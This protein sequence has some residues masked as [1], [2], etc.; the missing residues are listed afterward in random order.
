MYDAQNGWTISIDKVYKV[1]NGGAD[2]DY[3]FSA[4]K[5]LLTAVSA[6]DTDIAYVFGRNVSIF[7]TRDGGMNWDE[8]SNGT[9]N[10]LAS[11]FFLN[12]I[13]GW[14]GGSNHTMLH[15]HD[16][17]EHWLYTELPANYAVRDI[18]FTTADSGW[19]VNGGV[20]RTTDGGHYWEEISSSYP[21]YGIFVSLIPKKAGVW[22]RRHLLR[23]VNG[24]ESWEELNCGTGKSY[25][26]C[27]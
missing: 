4:E 1:T 27:L 21:P 7:T 2:A 14:A 26:V 10:D 16:G 17:G 11:V 18:Q 24:G 22:I 15:T 5:S 23:T 9:Q 13:E 8:K 25:S 20:W 19:L 3:S 6:P 12:E